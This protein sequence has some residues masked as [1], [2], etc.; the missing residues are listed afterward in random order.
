MSLRLKKLRNSKNINKSEFSRLM[1]VTFKTITNWEKKNGTIPSLEVTYQIAQVLQVPTFIVYKCFVD[2]PDFEKEN[3]FH[4]NHHNIDDLY[5]I[6]NFS[7]LKK[8]INAKKIYGRGILRIENEMIEFDNI[9]LDEIS[10]YNGYE[11]LIDLMTNPKKS[12]FSNMILLDKYNNIV[13]LKDDMIGKCE[14]ISNNYNNISFKLELL[15]PICP[16]SIVPCDLYLTIF[17]VDK[18][19][20]NYINHINRLEILDRKEVIP[21]ALKALHNRKSIS[22][23]QFADNM[24]I[25][26]KLLNKWETGTLAPPL[27][28][29]KEIAAKNNVSEELLFDCYDS[30]LF[31]D[32]CFDVVNNIYNVG[33][34]YQF[35]IIDNV[36]D[37]VSFLENYNLVKTAIFNDGIK[38]IIVFENENIGYIEKIDKECNEILLIIKD[39]EYNLNF[40]DIKYIKACSLHSNYYYEFIGMFLIENKEIRFILY[41]SIFGIKGSG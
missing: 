33:L 36:S 28:K 12:V 22:Q 35:N 9:I 39:E 18:K 1:N 13:L 17:E 30:G 14:K 8:Y 37:F 6:S 19:H 20:F 2:D 5:K 3:G 23:S 25:D 41:L 40:D 7:G 15:K 21:H 34:A 11:E 26:K 4:F 10:D 32:M 38:G 27:L 31:S 24:G 16:K 29:I